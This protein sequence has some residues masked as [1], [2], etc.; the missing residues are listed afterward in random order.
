[1]LIYYKGAI[2]SAV[3]TVKME[4]ITKSQIV[5][6]TFIFVLKKGTT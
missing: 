1:M 3:I 4:C 2:F 5:I 6:K